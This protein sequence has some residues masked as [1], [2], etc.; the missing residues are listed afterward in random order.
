MS[1]GPGQRLPKELREQAIGSII[2]LLAAGVAEREV[3]QQ[4]GERYR[5]SKRTT[6]A[7]LQAAYRR[8]RI[9]RKADR[10]RQVSLALQRRRLVMMRAARSGAWGVYL[11]AAESEARLL[12]LNEQTPIE[13]LT[14]VIRN[15][16]FDLA[17]ILRAVLPD[18]GQRR[19]ILDQ[20]RDRANERVRDV[21]KRQPLVLPAATSERAAPTTNREPRTP[22]Q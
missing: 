21:A 11:A 5:V 22:R 9:Q 2:D 18:P 10:D 4:V 7:W 8:L 1:R 3:R 19:L 6:F 15:I 13:R 20:L 16:A 14:E 12:G 17:D